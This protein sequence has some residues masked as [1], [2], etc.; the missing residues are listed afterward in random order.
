[1]TKTK[2]TKR[3]LLMSALSL[4]MCVSMLIGSTFAW[5]T[6]SVS[7]MNNIIKSGNLD[8]ELEYYDG[9]SWEKVTA[10]TNVFEENTL[11]E[12]GHTEVVY[13]RVSNLGT[14][15]L[16]YN[17]G[18]NIVSEIE[19]INVAGETLRLSDYIKFGAIEDVETPYADRKAALDA[20]AEAKVL[21]AG[22]T[23]A[24]SIEAG[25]DADYVAL[26]VYMP[27]TVGNEANYRTGE[28][29]PEITLG[30]NLM[31]TQY[32][33][34]KD[35]F[36]NQYDA[37]ARFDGVPAANVTNL[38]KMPKVTSVFTSEEYTLDTAYVFN[39]T[40]T[41]DEA[42]KNA[43]RF[44]HADFVASFDQDIDASDVGLAGAYDY[45][46]SGKW[47]AFEIDKAFEAKGDTNTFIAANTP[48]RMLEY[49]GI[50]MNY[51]ELC[52]LVK[53]F[54]CGAFAVDPAAMAGKTMTVELRLYETTKDPN[55]TGGPA[56]IET[57]EYI[58]VGTYNYTFGAK[59]VSTVAEMQK[60][61]ANGGE[62][63]LVA[64]INVSN[65]VTLADVPAGVSATLDLNGHNIT[66]SLEGSAG[67]SQI[68]HVGKDAALTVK[69][70]G[71]VHA[72][73]YPTTAYG[74]VIFNNVG[75][76]LTINGGTY[77]MDYGTYADGYLLPSIVDTN[78]NIGKATTIINGGTFYHN[79]NMFRNFAQPKRG[80]NN[81]TLI[82]NG[83]TFNGEADDYA[84]I[85][86]QKTNN[87]GVV[88]D[89]VVKLNGG[90][91]NYIDITNDFQD[92]TCIYIDPSITNVAI[93]H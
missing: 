7:S 37:D 54:S 18:I 89:G 41:Y 63:A 51:E 47:V 82:I 92:N 3:A 1:M 29:A 64:D 85:W 59:K 31:A 22:Y 78:S 91:F 73:A 43:K 36:D 46:N 56:N 21:S 57:G 25:A 50:S 76:T 68:F 79:R 13:L 8:V 71:N 10:T 35:S 86:N 20:V 58:T 45:F 53:K 69:G 16:K 70:N 44:W 5:F 49:A 62:V 60:V 11:W 66:A 75:G 77:T 23:K 2:S 19:S 83:G 39:T 28:V 65:V 81:A 88:G 74:S 61:F 32:T 30:L 33:S 48:I 72:V 93:K 84:S 17:L 34:E 26:V 55:A 52:N 40:E 14:L 24:G 67:W 27:E 6:D 38:K 42:Q 12:P 87:D 90:T 80:A 4:L 9:D 15:A